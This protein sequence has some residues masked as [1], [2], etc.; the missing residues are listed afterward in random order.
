MK[1]YQAWRVQ[2]FVVICGAHFKQKH[3]QFWSNFEFDRNTVKGACANDGDM[4]SRKMGAIWLYDE[5]YMA[6]RE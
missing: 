3:S 1:M 5:W 2:H 4:S 6:C